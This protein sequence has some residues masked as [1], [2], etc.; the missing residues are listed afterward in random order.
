MATQN[1]YIFREGQSTT[2]PPYFD[3]NDYPYWKI[4]MRI[5]LQVLD[6]EIWEIVNDDSF[7]PTTKNKEGEKFSKPSSQWNE[8]EK[9]KTLLNSKVIKLL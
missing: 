5:Y 8:L 3:G 7:L 9:R 2:R 6:Y 1:D 4:I